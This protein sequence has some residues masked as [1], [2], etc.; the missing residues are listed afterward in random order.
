MRASDKVKYAS[1]VNSK[2]TKKFWSLIK[3]SELFQSLL[4]SATNVNVVATTTVLDG[5]EL[6]DDLKSCSDRGGICC[7]GLFLKMNRLNA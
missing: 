4:D 6:D 2:V 3:A 7:P 1:T 5:N